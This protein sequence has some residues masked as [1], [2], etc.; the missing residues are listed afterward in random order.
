[1]QMIEIVAYVDDAD[2][3]TPHR[4]PPLEILTFGRL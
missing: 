4:L 2:E 3:A 1:M